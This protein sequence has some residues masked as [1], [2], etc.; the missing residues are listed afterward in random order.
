MG[1]ST[2]PDA[3]ALSQMVLRRATPADLPEVVAL[4]QACYG[5]PWPAS[6]FSSLTDNPRVFF[7]VAREESRG[8][9]TGYVIAWYVMDEGE[10]ANLAVAP[11]DRTR[12]VGRALLDAM[13][14][15]A[16]ARG[17]AEVYLEVRESNSAALKLY[18]ARDFVPVGRRTGYYRTPKEDALILRRTLKT[19]DAEGTPAFE[20]K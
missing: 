6:A 19:Q 3:S 1:S 5:D 20:V 10:L 4:E 17:T 15:D 16:A 8:R 2:R 12:G 9:L 18:S 11:A 14:D 7:A 13:L